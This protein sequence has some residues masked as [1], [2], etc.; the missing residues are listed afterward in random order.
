MRVQNIS[1]IDKFFS[2]VESCEG[3]VELCTGEGDRLNLKSALARYVAL[4]KVF[5]D[6]STV[7]EVELV[8]YNRDDIDKFLQFMIENK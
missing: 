6:G 7:P 8:V 5:S 3:R 4:A 1:D 2:V